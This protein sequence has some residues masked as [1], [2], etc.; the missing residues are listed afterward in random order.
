MKIEGYLE[1]LGLV[2]EQLE[3]ADRFLVVEQRE[4]D[5]R[6]FR[7]VEPSAA[8]SLAGTDES[9]MGEPTEARELHTRSLRRW[10]MGASGLHMMCPS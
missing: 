2:V 1:L 7:L 4:K 8:R 6:T 5:V 3:D 9:L 10:N